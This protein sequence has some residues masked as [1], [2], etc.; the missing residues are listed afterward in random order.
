MDSMLTT[1]A[2]IA[3]HAAFSRF[4]A[5]TGGIEIPGATSTLSALALKSPSFQETKQKVQADITAQTA[6]MVPTGV[7]DPC[8][9]SVTPSQTKF[10][11]G[12]D[13]LVLYAVIGGTQEKN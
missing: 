8:A 12:K 6:K 7:L 13:S 9:L 10:K 3:D 11:F 2:G 1:A 5:G 4:V